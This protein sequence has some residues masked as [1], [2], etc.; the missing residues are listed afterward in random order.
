M[1]RRYQE[2]CLFREKRKT[3]PA[4][5]VFR[6]R[7]GQHNRKQQV[8]TLEQDPTR[9]EAMK[10]CEQ[11]RVTINRE[12]RTPRIFGELT[13]HYIRHELPNK[14]PYTGEVYKGYLTTGFVRSGKGTL[15]RM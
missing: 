7:D 6:F 8:G 10:A 2:G 1:S 11:L 4:V 15:F 3:G 5:W 12:V 13:D 9:S 14:T